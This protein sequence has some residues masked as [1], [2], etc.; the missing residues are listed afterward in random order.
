MSIKKWLNDLMSI[1]KWLNEY[2]D[3]MQSQYSF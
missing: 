2:Y 1:K 3:I